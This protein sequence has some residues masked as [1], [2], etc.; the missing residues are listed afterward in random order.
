MDASSN[1]HSALFAVLPSSLRVAHSHFAAPQRVFHLLLRSW[2]QMLKRS[3]E[4]E[5]FAENASS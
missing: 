5:R 2:N 4:P 1:C 3:P